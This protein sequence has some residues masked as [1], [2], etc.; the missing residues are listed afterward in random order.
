[1]TDGMA[2]A[3]TGAVPGAKPRAM[4][5]P[6]TGNTTG[7]FTDGE[8][9]DRAKNCDDGAGVEERG[10]VRG[11]RTAWDTV[12]PT[13]SAAGND[14]ATERTAARATCP[15]GT[16]GTIVSRAKTCRA[17]VG[18]TVPSGADGATFSRAG[19]DPDIS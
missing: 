19:T 6:L 15:P 9:S 7:A 18:V 10:G 12:G 4:T 3:T 11:G 13:G 1:M 16:V 14:G 8:P 5:G 2:G 17:A